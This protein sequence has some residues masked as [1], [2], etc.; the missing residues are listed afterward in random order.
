MMGKS[1]LWHFEFMN[2][3]KLCA[4]LNVPISYVNSRVNKTNHTSNVRRKTIVCHFKYIL[5]IQYI[6][7]DIRQSHRVT[8]LHSIW[9]ISCGGCFLSV[10]GCRLFC[11]CIR[12]CNG[13][14]WYV[15]YPSDPAIHVQTSSVCGIVCFSTG[16]AAHVC[17]PMNSLSVCWDAVTRTPKCYLLGLPTLQIKLF[18][19]PQLKSKLRTCLQRLDQSRLWRTDLYLLPFIQLD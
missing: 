1:T 6:F 13:Y 18:P 8:T 16:P 10:C 12:L 9:K 14:P 3:Q 5:Y 4:W 17:R 15:N 11:M 19:S 7:W 2:Q